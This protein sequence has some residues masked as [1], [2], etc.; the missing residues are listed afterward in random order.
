MRKLLILLI[1]I[2]NSCA[3]SSNDDNGD[4]LEAK[5][6]VELLGENV[7]HL[8]DVSTGAA[9]NS[10]NLGNDSIVKNVEYV[11]V[12]YPAKGDYTVELKVN[13][14]S[15]PT[16]DRYY[17]VISVSEDDLIASFIIEE[18]DSFNKY[19]FTNNSIGE[20]EK[21]IWDFGNGVTST[22]TNPHSIYYPFQGLYDVTL[23]LKKNGITVIKK[24]RLVVSQDDPDYLGN[25]E[26]V[27][28][29]EFDGSTV[30]M[31]NWTFET[32]ASGWGNNEW[33]NYTN[34]D[35][36]EVKDGMLIITAKLVGAGQKVGDYTSTRLISKGKQKF[37]RGR[38]E[39]RMKLPSGKGTWP[40]FWMLGENIDQV[41]W[42][43][44]GEI[45][46]MEHVG[47]DPLNVSAALHTAS[48]YGNTVNHKLVE[49]IG[50]E[51][52]FHV[53]G[54]IWTEE[55]MKFY[56]DTPDNIYYEYSPSTKN[57][58]T[59]PFYKDQFFILNI[60]V[61]GNWGGAQ[62]VDDSIFP[63]T[64]EIDYVRVYQLK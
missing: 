19:K 5:F 30:D 28:S 51:E 43:N 57:D 33:Q 20:Y 54:V 35:N 27:W 4:K 12:Y 26:L 62:G 6:T 14:S 61:G 50:S 11:D 34:G 59:W 49:L 52:N 53:Y 55:S 2:F 25:M 16:E 13:S 37:T 44:C 31:N 15:S 32:G 58:D 38:M 41:G 1:V 7:Y 29:D 21:I 8:T 64:M 56:I 22:E 48:S 45:D 39:A 23:S 47:Y 17:E 36:A 9:Y 63:Q 3:C 60:A 10:W 40:A 46:I 42:P 24:Q 18:E